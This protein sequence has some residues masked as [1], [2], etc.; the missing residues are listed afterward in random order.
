MIRVILVDDHVVVRSGFAQ[1]LNLEDDLD[2][3]GQY[4]SAAAALA[5]IAA[6]RRQRRG[7]GHRH[8]G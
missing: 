3:V 7:D 5:G 1:L 8:A 2:V 6:R 4:S